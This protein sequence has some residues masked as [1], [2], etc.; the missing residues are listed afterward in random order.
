MP[1]DDWDAM[2]NPLLDEITPSDASAFELELP[3][4]P[5]LDQM[6]EEGYT[7]LYKAALEGDLEG[8]QDLISRGAD[9]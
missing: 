5:D 8:V 9:P 6:D 1:N 4:N 2:H 7:P 3:F